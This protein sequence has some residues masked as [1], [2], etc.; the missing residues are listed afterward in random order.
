MW[1]SGKK[2]GIK[3]SSEMDEFMLNVFEIEVVYTFWYRLA[4]W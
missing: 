3:P 1:I 2:R 4:Q